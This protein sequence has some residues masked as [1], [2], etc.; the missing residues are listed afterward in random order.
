MAGRRP[1]PTALK[2]ITGNPGRRVMNAKEPKPRRA[3]PACPECLDD[4]GKVAWSRLSALLDGMGLLTLADSYA[5]ERLADIYSEILQCRTV[6]QRDGRT[7]T[8]TTKEGSTLK[9]SHPAVNQLRA[10]DAQFKSYMV[11]FGLTPSSRARVQTQAP[12]DDEKSLL[13]EFFV[14]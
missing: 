13:D 11:E 8:V 10:A 12:D 1:K 6:I 9:K 4:A 3:I 14:P 7:Y 2:L 5:L